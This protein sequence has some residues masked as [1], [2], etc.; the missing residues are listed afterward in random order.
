MS[1]DD[2]PKDNTQL[3]GFIIHILG[4]HEKQMDHLAN[5]LEETKTNLSAATQ[6]LNARLDRINKQMDYIHAQIEKF[7]A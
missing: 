5:K 2:Q 6:K 3:L 4:D 7:R 1:P